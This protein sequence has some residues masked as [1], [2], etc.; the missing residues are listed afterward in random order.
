VDGVRAGSQV[1][2]E[3]REENFV[4][5]RVDATQGLA[6]LL[7]QGAVRKV[8]SGVPLALLRLVRQP[9]SVHDMEA[10]E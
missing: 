4:V 1:R 9:D 10:S 8:E 7:K 6:D 5:L 3:G 2:V